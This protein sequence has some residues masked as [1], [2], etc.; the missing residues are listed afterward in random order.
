MP[1]IMI[2]RDELRPRVSDAGAAT[3]LAERFTGKNGTDAAEERPGRC[4]RHRLRWKAAR[5]IFRRRKQ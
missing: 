1:Q 3:I 5:R 2:N 4:S